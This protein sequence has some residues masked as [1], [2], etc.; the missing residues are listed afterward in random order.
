MDNVLVSQEFLPELGFAFEL[1]RKPIKR[2]YLR[3]RPPDGKITVNAPLNLPMR[4]IHALIKQNHAWILK[5]QGRLA[6]QAPS[7]PEARVMHGQTLHVLGEPHTLNI[8]PNALHNQLI[9]VAG[10]M[11]IKS[12]IPLE[13]EQIRARI[14][15]HWRAELAGVL[16]ERL[17]FWSEKIGVTAHFIGIKHMKTRWGSC[18]IKDQR[19]WINLELARMPQACIDLVLVH[20]LTHLWER[21]HNARFYGLMD[22]FMPTWR[23]HQAELKRWGMSNL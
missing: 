6:N 17:P 12:K 14:H 2:A 5:N 13:P 20:E 9:C 16:N 3:V 15:T 1:T 23:T 8:Q 4:M 21:G 11:H 18:N 22:Q 19:I 7:A 10:V